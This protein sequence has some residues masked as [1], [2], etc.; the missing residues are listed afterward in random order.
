MLFG[1]TIYIYKEAYAP[2]FAVLMVLM[3]GYGIAN[4]FYWDRSLLLAFGRAELPL[5]VSFLAMLGKIGL[6]FL[7]V[8]VLGYLSEAALLS[9]YFV[10]TV[11]ILVW[12]GLAEIRHQ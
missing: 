8:P 6:A 4:T 7:I 9:A 12:K 1:R 5:R 11:S 2:A 10:V 3:V